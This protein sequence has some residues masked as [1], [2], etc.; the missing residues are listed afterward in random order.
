[1]SKP[2][3]DIT[4]QGLSPHSPLRHTCCCLIRQ[5]NTVTFEAFPFCIFLAKEMVIFMLSVS[6]GCFIPQRQTIEEKS[7]A[8]SNELGCFLFNWFEGVL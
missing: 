3:D 4:S 8:V 7:F 5:M 6:F 1:M 2:S